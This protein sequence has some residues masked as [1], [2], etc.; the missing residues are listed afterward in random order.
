MKKVPLLLLAL[1]LSTVASAGARRCPTG[2]LNGD[3]KVDRQDLA[4][5]AHQWLVSSPTPANLDTINAVNLTDFALLAENW[6]TRAGQITLVIN[7]FMA[8][9]DGSI[10]D[11]YGDYDD[12]I[13]IY[14]YGDEAV[15]I[16]GMYL[17]D[18]LTS[19]GRWRVPDTNPSL[20]T[21]PSHG[22]L[23]IWADEEAGEGILHASFKLSAGGEQIGLYDAGG[24][25]IDSIVFGPQNGN[26]SYGRLPDGSDN[27][28]V[29]R[30]STPGRPNTA[31]P[32]EVV[33]NEIMYH[34]YHALNTPENMGQ[35]YIE[36]FNHGAE[37]AN[38]A[39][40]R[41]T[42]G[43]DFLFPEVTL[44][45]GQYLVVAADV[46]VFIAKY[47]GVSNVVGGWDGRLS[48]MGEAIE[49]VDATGVRID[50]I[51]Y[52][53]E[54]DWS[55][56]QLGPVD[57]SHRGWEWSDAHDGGG[58]SLELINPA[59]PNEYGQNWAASNVNGGT[60]GRANSVAANDVA[61]L[62]LDV[63]HSPIIPGPNDAVIVTA[64]IINEQ[65]TGL[66]VTLNCRVDGQPAFAKLSMFDDGRH[67]DGGS[68][69]R[70][71]GAEI[72]AQPDGAIIEFY[73]EASDAGS[74]ARTWPAPSLVD[75]VPQQVTNA[76]YQVDDSFDPD[77]TPGSQPVYYV[78]MTEKERAEL[79]FIGSRS[80]GEEDSDAQMNGT[81][82]SID[83]TGAEL[84]YDVGI[85]NRGHG[86]RTG[87][88][89]NQHVN[90]PHN[91]PWKD[92]SGISFNCRY[93]HAQIIGSAIFR[94]AGLVAAETVPVQLRI[95]G[96]NLAS[97]GSP[98]YGVYARLEAFNNDFADKHFPDDPAGNLYTC[99]RTDSNVQAE[100]LYEG[101]NP[102][103]YRNRYFKANNETQDDWSD[104]IHMLDVLNNAPDATYLQDVSKVI[105]VP[106]WL[107]YIALN[108]LLENND[109]TR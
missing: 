8:K 26:E 75:N 87:P 88:P 54:G 13:E 5:F 78:I 43:V 105:N 21:I 23:L 34:P 35:E 67:G 22:Y 93:T 83:G 103:T 3:C 16:G 55:V 59:M 29:F 92:V 41:F 64:R 12:W 32:V 40:W 89:N 95:N 53:D 109:I 100:L 79:A 17:A 56:R 72:P 71:Y 19:A 73:I 104:L 52:A 85:R 80:N 84:C 81:F 86:T 68:G 47:P 10:L 66:T 90:F 33:I 51:H 7:E 69:D 106:Q 70:V 98:M 94:M 108:S 46:N 6:L 65:T 45:A 76:L 38:L 107:R 42:N 102:N 49:L 39:G 2:D 50:W 36:L 62:I 11:P 74:H 82:I 20:T 30:A 25:L 27:W 61:P 77:W 9:N 97:T 96:A 99:F 48:N 101:T 44:G 14:N 28:Q 31:E 91:R 15:D 4:I 63:A 57:R 60:P 58:K 24:N 18:N 1:T 37:P